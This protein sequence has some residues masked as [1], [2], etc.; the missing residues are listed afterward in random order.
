MTLWVKLRALSNTEPS[1]KMFY[2][3]SEPQAVFRLDVLI[4]VKQADIM[5]GGGRQYLP[6]A[7][8]HYKLD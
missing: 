8:H 7:E 4:F 2:T 5:K 1:P 3:E 6:H